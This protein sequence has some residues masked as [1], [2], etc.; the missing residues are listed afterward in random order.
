MA[1]VYVIANLFFLLTKNDI[2]L[3]Y[4]KFSNLG[5]DHANFPKE[6]FCYKITE[7]FTFFTPPPVVS[8]LAEMAHETS[9]FI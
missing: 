8:V 3:H 7:I 6:N 4:D 9:S 1:K 2:I 5:V